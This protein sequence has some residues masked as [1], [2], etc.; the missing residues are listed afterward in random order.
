[1][2]V[3]FPICT[4]VKFS[5]LSLLLQKELCSPSVSRRSSFRNSNFVS[6]I[7]L[8]F[9]CVYMGDVCLCMFVCVYICMSLCVFVCS[10]YC[11]FVYAYVCA[12]RQ[13]KTETET[14]SQES[15]E[16]TV[17]TSGP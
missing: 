10:V 14:V 7:T 9:F 12:C 6:N 3:A 16:L 2:C 11:V 13:A 5:Q 8:K 1:M 15:L 17:Q 4:D